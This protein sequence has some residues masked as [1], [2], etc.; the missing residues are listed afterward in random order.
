MA[1]PETWKIGAIIA[2]TLAITGT[3][4]V[5]QVEDR[6]ESLPEANATTDSRPQRGPRGAA[7]LPAREENVVERR[8]NPVRK[9]GAPVDFSYEFASSV[10][11]GIDCTV[12][13]TVTSGLGSAR[14]ECV[15]SSTDSV[16][17]LDG[18]FASA[19]EAGESHVARFVLRPERAGRSYVPVRISVERADGTTTSR[20]FAIPVVCGAA[21]VRPSEVAKTRDDRGTPI[22]VLKARQT[23]R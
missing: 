18:M 4:L 14:L 9:P 10:K 19:S 22:R 6:A 3:V 5:W 8:S 17:V 7:V 1:R 2:L 15:A 20:A 11:L 13:V 16:T 21:D 23:I 12:D